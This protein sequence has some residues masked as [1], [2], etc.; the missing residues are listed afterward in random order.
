[1]WAP[2]YQP[3]EETFIKSFFFILAE[4]LHQ[5]F[6]MQLCQNEFHKCDIN[7][8]QLFTRIFISN[9][10]SLLYFFPS[11]NF[12]NLSHHGHLWIAPFSL[13]S[14]ARAILGNLLI[15]SWLV[16]S[17]E[18]HCNHPQ[19]L[20]LTYHASWSLSWLDLGKF[21]IRFD[22]SRSVVNGYKGSFQ[23]KF[24]VKV[25]NLAQPAWPPPPSPYVRIPKKEKKN[26]VYFA[27]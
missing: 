14:L 16:L 13:G 23:N 12:M 2:L 6:S 3:S 25:G 18:D 19:V 17:F 4:I 7:F 1:M 9:G 11:V 26:Y 8:N 22:L 24:S 10:F 21:K 15:L 5:P 27:F 20:F